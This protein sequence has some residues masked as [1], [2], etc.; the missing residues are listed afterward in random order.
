MMPEHVRPQAPDDATEDATDEAEKPGAPGA[1]D[2]RERPASRDTP[3]DMSD[4]DVPD[5]PAVRHDRTTVDGDAQRR[6]DA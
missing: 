3:N 5:G 4:E 2:G 6:G 1:N